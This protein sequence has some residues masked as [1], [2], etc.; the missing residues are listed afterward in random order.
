[1]PPSRASGATLLAPVMRGEPATGGTIVGQ[2]ALTT[3]MRG[4]PIGTNA[5]APRGVTHQA[6]PASPEMRSVVVYLKGATPTGALPIVRAQ[7]RQEHESFFPRM[8]AVT[9]GSTIDFPNFD[10][11]LPQRVLAFGRR[12]V[13]PRSLPGRAVAIPAVRQG[14]DRQGLLPHPF[15]DERDH[16]GARPPL[17]HDTGCRRTIHDRRSSARRLHARR[18]ARARRRAGKPGD[19]V[20]GA[21]DDGR[22]IAPGRRGPR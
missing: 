4:V 11:V 3:R 12:H 13:R 7:I 10:P 20:G 15:A 9:R 6:P 14:R 18:M 21:H 22:R 19:G 17:F 2:V 8:V 1:M 16:R 5:Y